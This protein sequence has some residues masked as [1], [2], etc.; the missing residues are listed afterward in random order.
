MLKGKKASFALGAS[1]SHIDGVVPTRVKKEQA[2][3]LQYQSSLIDNR[4]K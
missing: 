2:E 4:L 1:R 3:L